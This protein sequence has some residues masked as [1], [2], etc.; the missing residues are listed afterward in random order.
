M[1]GLCAPAKP[2][3]MA[4]TRIVTIGFILIL[5]PYFFTG[6]AVLLAGPAGSRSW[7]K[8]VVVRQVATTLSLGAYWYACLTFASAG[9]CVDATAR[10]ETL[11]MRSTF[12]SRSKNPSI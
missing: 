12:P 11:T 4:Q 5:S 7:L 3:A 2:A 6:A 9:L 8:Y 1:L 10:L